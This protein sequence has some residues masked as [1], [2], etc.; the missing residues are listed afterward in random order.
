MAKL[1]PSKQILSVK[2]VYYGPGLCGKT[3][4][5]TALHNA[6]APDRRGDLVSLDTE[7]ER[8]LFFDYFDAT[9]G[10]I[11]GFTVKVDF[12]TV[13][14]QSFYN[15]TRRSVLKNVDG[16]VFVADSS[17]DREEA[18]CFALENLRDNLTSQRR[19]LSEIP[20]VFQWN[21]RD[22]RSA[23]PVSLMEELLNPNKAPSFSAI[24]LRGE[25]VLATQTEILR[26]VMADINKRSALNARR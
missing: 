15:E 17:T 24:A 20:L 18:N 11:Q 4:N 22:L 3:T 8:T 21:K 5:L 14:G 13:P 16:V 19:E 7:T 25:G 23:L 9:I 2:I 6:Y 10:K 26:L 12:F 1:I